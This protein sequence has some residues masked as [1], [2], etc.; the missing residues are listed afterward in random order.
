MRAGVFDGEYITLEDIEKPKP[1]GEEILIEVRACGICGTDVHILKGEFPASEPVV[2]GHELAGEVVSKG[3]EVNGIDIGDKVSVNPNISCGKCTYCR[4]GKPNLCENLQAIGVHR[5]GGFGEY[6][7]IPQN[8][9]HVFQDAEF[10]EGAFSE[11]IACCLRG[12]D[13]L[14]P[15][16]GE[17]AAVF[18]GGAIG[19]LMLQLLKLSGASKVFLSEPI[20]ERRNMAEKLGA[21]RVIDPKK[22]NPVEVIKSETDGIGVDNTVEA[23][24]LPTIFEDCIN[25]AKKGGSIL[26]FGV[27]PPEKESRI[28]PYQVYKK[29]LSIFGSFVNPFTQERAVRLIESGDLELKQLITHE[30]AL[31]EI[32]KGIELM[33]S[34]QGIKVIIKP[35]L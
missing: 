21:F 17:T 3:N 1:R 32:R 5:N 31:K 14:D 27:S 20:E 35:Q 6:V 23:A 9:A 29:E 26:Q 7:T 8:K 18:G 13:R 2:L 22:Y 19:L 33:E 16:E 10:I 11:P 12:I 28:R 25:V 34:N 30:L 15:N 24:G 4:S